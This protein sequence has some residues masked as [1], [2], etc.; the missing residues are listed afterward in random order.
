MTAFT[1]VFKQLR[2]LLQ[3][4][5]FGFAGIALA[6]CGYNNV[7]TLEQQAKGAWREVQ[8]QYQLRADLIPGLVE[9]F[10][11]VAQQKLASEEHDIL[12]SVVAAKAKAALVQVD[13]S[14]ITNPSRFREFQDAQLDLAS[15]LGRL[16]EVSE[17]HPELKAHQGF[18]S[19]RE[20]LDG[21]EN[22]I[23]VARLDYA[24][25]VRAH[26]SEVQG[27]PGLIWARLFWGA[28]PMATF[29]SVPG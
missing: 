4:A 2:K 8:N 20:Q 7:P 29:A 22:R 6:G 19:A 10:K 12:N 3:V 26:N 28:R 25:A 24:E 17:R 5:L 9:T 27:F 1:R 21:I 11:S 23:S 18:M 14:T 15:A 16:G 13:A